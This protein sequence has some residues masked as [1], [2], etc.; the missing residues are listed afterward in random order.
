MKDKLTKNGHK[1][2]Y[3]HIRRFFIGTVVSASLLTAIGI[4]TYLLIK[5]NVDKQTLAEEENTDETPESM[6]QFVHYCSD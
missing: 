4:P 5:N 3:Y 1:G 2:M 6:V